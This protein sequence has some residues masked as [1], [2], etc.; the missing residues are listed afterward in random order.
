MPRRQPAVEVMARLVASADFE[1]VL[2]S[3]SRASTLHFAVHHLPAAEAA[4]PPPLAQPARRELSTIPGEIGERPVDDLPG[5]PPRRLGVVVPKRHARRA[6]T[7]S[8]LKRQIYAAGGRHA[9]TLAHG[10]W[11]VR[12]RAP[13]DRTRFVSAASPALREVA[14]AEL[15]DL[16]RAAS[17]S[18]PR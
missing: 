18:R 16:F 5:E 7:R 4:T 10:L 1:R 11:I 13:F 15:E 2:G 14:R 3:R 6:V 8:L 12:L 9:A 17:S